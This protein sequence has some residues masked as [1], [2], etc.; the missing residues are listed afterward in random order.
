MYVEKYISFPRLL[1]MS[2]VHLLWLTLW[3]FGVTALYVY[4]DYKWMEV[5]WLP[6]SVIGTAVAFYVGFK[7]NQAYDRLWEARKIWGAIVNESRAWGAGVVSLV[8][9]DE[10][11]TE[12][13][14]EEVRAIRQRLVYRQIAWLYTLRNQLLVVQPW[15][16]RSQ[17]GLFTRRTVRALDTLGLM[18]DKVLEQLLYD[19]LPERECARLKS[20]RNS[21]TQILTRQSQDLSHL[22]TLGLINDFRHIKFQESVDALLAEQGKC[23]RIKNFPLPRQ[24]AGMSNIFVGIF[25]FL[26]PFGMASEFVRLGVAWQW[27][28][29]PFTVV[30]SWVFLMME[31]VGDYS[32]NPFQDC[33][34]T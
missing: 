1:Q 28:A 25:I 21:A 2:G 22:Y 23:E 5:P 24:Y 16:H 17:Q 32:E 26:L 18:D 9:S 7:N 33:E 30:V 6:L 31:L 11:D 34:M 3:A 20:V 29:V 15:E 4:G 19:Y 13:S 10:A 12:L 14:R 27:L 8:G